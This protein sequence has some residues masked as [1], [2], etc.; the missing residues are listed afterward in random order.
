MMAS[1][2]VNCAE[3]HTRMALKNNLRGVQ[4]FLCKMDRTVPMG[5]FVTVPFSALPRPI[6]NYLNVPKETTDIAE[7][8]LNLA[9]DHEH[10]SFAALTTSR[11]YPEQRWIHEVHAFYSV[12]FH[13]DW[14]S[15]EIER[16]IL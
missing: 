5:I 9:S 13:C 12:I 6:I 8:I 1:N 10:L 14:V 11:E 16:M 15:G 7:Y 2:R 3:C 4:R